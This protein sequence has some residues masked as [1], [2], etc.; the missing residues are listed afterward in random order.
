MRH[1]T[2]AG[3]PVDRPRRLVQ[4]GSALPTEFRAGSDPTED[5]AIDEGEPGNLRGRQ[6]DGIDAARKFVRDLHRL[7]AAQLE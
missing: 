4:I 2:A 5:V 1:D 6:L 7:R 3:H